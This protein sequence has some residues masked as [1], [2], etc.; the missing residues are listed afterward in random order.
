MKYEICLRKFALI[1]PTVLS[2]V[3]PLIT[4]GQAPSPPRPSASLAFT[5]TDG[6]C[7]PQ[8]VSSTAGLTAITVNMSSSKPQ[9]ISLST[10]VQSKKYVF[11]HTQVGASERWTTMIVL[12]TGTYELASS[13][14]GGKCTITVQ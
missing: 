9:Q 6:N 13:L 3:C 14:G 2:M 5:V 1:S 12:P 11:G 4:A 8:A 7:S 10:T